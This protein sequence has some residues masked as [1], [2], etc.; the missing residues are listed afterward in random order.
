MEERIKALKQGKE[1]LYN[2]LASVLQEK[3]LMRP[4]TNGRK[5]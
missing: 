3:D 5:K 4:E 1:Q 2:N